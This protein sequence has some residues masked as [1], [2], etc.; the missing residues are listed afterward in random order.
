MSESIELAGEHVELLPEHALLWPR[1]A[2]LLLA[3]LHLGKDEVFRR[4]GIAVPAGS[5]QTDLDRLAALIRVHAVQRVVLLGDFVHAVPQ[6]GSEFIPLFM[7][8]RAAHA[9]LEF[10]VVAGNHDR[11]AARQQLTT[12]Q[13]QSQWLAAPFV[14]QHHPGDSLHGYVLCGHAHPVIRIRTGRERMRL[15]TFWFTPQFG[16]LPS[17][18][19]F[20]GGAE[21]EPGPRDE[22]FA[23]AADRVWRV[24]NLRGD[25]SV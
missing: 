21:I 24:P 19:S 22:V 18:G 20:T 8:W 2:T 10:I 9:E 3:D 11:L 13:W 12:I 14:G 16:V 23:V 5:S 6:F 7:A 1:T 17:F 25:K 15:P 4:S